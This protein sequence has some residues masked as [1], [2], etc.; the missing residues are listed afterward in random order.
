MCG[1]ALDFALFC[2]SIFSLFCYFT[3]FSYDNAVLFDYCS[4]IITIKTRNIKYE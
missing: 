1:P 2:Y 4:F 3:L